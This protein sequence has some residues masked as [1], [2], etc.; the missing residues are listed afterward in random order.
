[1]FSIKRSASPLED[2]TKKKDKNVNRGKINKKSAE[3][4]K[5]KDFSRKIYK[6]LKRIGRMLYKE[7]LK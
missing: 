1:L 6:S 5:G 7:K 2:K 4:K 3:K